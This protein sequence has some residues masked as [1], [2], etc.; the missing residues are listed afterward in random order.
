MFERCVALAWCSE[1]RIYTGAMVHVPRS[2][3]LVDAL[4]SLPSDDRDRLLRGEAKLVEH[5]D[6]HAGRPA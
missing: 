2:H 6:R 5:L 1:C 4:A 3:T